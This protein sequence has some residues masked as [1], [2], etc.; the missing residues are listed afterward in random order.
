M[1]DSGVPQRH[2]FTHPSRVEHWRHVSE[3]VALA[4]AAVWALYV[5]VY[6]EQVKPARVPPEISSVW[7][8]DHQS[9]SSGAELVRVDVVSKNVGSQT[10]YIAGA[11]VSVYGVR[12]GA[13]PREWGVPLANGFGVFNRS[14]PEASSTLLY[15]YVHAFPPFHG[16]AAAEAYDIPPQA[17]SDRIYSFAIRPHAYDVARLEWVACLTKYPNRTWPVTIIRKSDGSFG[18]AGAAGAAGLVC[19]SSIHDEFPL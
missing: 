3:I 7:T 17:D 19:Y 1:S 15:S 6:Q 14:L 4:I 2:V 13:T 12:F 11:I 18:F 8:V 16:T 5:F 10:F 9:L